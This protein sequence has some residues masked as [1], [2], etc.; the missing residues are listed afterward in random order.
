MILA[1]AAATSVPVEAERLKVMIWMI[2]VLLA[3]AAFSFRYRLYAIPTAPQKSSPLT[4]GMVFGAFM[5]YFIL[6]LIVLNVFLSLI[7]HWYG[8]PTEHPENLLTS[9]WQVWLNFGTISLS[10]LCL[11]IYALNLNPNVRALLWNREQK[12]YRS[13]LQ[14][15]RIGMI[16]WLAAFPFVVFVNQGTEWLISYFLRAPVQSE[17]Q[18]AI[19]LLKSIGY[20]QSMIIAACIV[21]IAF[22]PIGEELL[23]RGFLQSWIRK[24]L[25]QPWAI[26]LTSAAFAGV[27]FSLSQGIVNIELIA[28][29]F[30]LSCILGLIYEWRG[31]LWAP[32]ALH[33]TFNSVTVFMLFFE[34]PS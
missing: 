1:E 12:P 18:T 13:L 5:T 26:L 22:V 31:S 19:R 23:F 9:F 28:S 14:D 4:I 10:T 3:L 25:G 29:L 6:G 27:H 11:M 24:V 7:L 20:D 34:N 16:M 21:I 8:G 15:F 32:I 2:P 33:S 17:Q 30:V